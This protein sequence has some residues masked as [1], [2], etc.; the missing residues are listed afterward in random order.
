M[1]AVAQ[2]NRGNND[3]RLIA[4][5]AD[6]RLK[7]SEQAVYFVLRGLGMKQKEGPNGVPRLEIF[8]GKQ[9]QLF[10][11][12]R[13]L[14][15]RHDGK[16]MILEPKEDPPVDGDYASPAGVN[17]KL[18]ASWSAGDLRNVR[19][20][21]PAN[22]LG[23]LGDSQY[24]GSTTGSFRSRSV[25]R[26]T[27]AE[28]NDFFEELGLPKVLAVNSMPC[29]MKF[30][31][32]AEIEAPEKDKTAKV[33][34]VRRQK[35]SDA[36]MYAYDE[37]EDGDWVAPDWYK[38]FK[39]PGKARI[40]KQQSW[41]VEKSKQYSHKQSYP[42]PEPPWVRGGPCWKNPDGQHWRGRIAANDFLK[43][44]AAL[45]TY[46]EDFQKYRDAVRDDWDRKEMRTA[47]EQAALVPAWGGPDVDQW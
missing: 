7:G 6:V 1:A 3:S 29:N 30:A 21:A 24:L 13:R 38:D 46:Q 41:C 9:P 2:R 4:A 12:L 5:L 15:L 34:K 33:K 26:L 23:G 10:N 28:R 8:A 45:A 22:G 25:T 37:E 20:H 27:P 32:K 31:V 43:R 40:E 39:P 18:G 44:K 11:A 47:A 16:R 42:I 35:P 36:D 17:S 19:Q 14:G